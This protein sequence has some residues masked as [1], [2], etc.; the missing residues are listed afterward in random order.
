LIAGMKKLRARL[1]QSEYEIKIGAGLL[2]RA[3]REMAAL[4]FKDKCVIIT[5]PVLERLYGARLKADLESAGCAAGL[6]AVP[7]GEE[8]KSLEWAGRLYDRLCDLR[9]ER[10]TPVLALGGGVIGDLAGFVAATYLRGVPLVQLPTSLLAM[11]DSSVGGKVAVDHGRLKNNVG[12]FYQP[13]LV[14]ADIST[15]RTLPAFE[16][17]NGLAECIKYAIIRDEGLFALL[18]RRTG[19][20]KGGDEPLLEEIISRCVAIKAAIVEQDERDLGPRNI[21]NFGH[22][23]GHAI[24]SV[25]NFGVPHGRAVAVGMVTAAIISVKAGYL[26][27]A[28]LARIE[29]LIEKAGLSCRLP[30]GISLPAILSAVQYDK[31]KSSRGLRFVLARKI[32]EGFLEDGVE[33][34]LVEEA[35][36]EQNG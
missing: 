36:R 19:D 10:L 4:G 34:A 18:E 13:R 29:A 17:E 2:R 20:I 7:E 6:V 27:A 30:A 14:L 8:Q 12:T 26:G 31:K 32:G 15:F 24:E 35:L 3:P 5:N 21:L 25:S 28:D 22:T 9:A 11:V 16:M 1:G 23:I 33:P